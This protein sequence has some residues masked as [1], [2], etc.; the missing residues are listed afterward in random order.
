[1]GHPS[2]G[3]DAQAITCGALMLGAQIV[4]RVVIGGDPLLPQALGRGSLRLEQRGRGG[5]GFRH[6]E[7][8][9]SHSLGPVIA[10]FEDQLR[11]P[12]SRDPDAP[13]IRVH[14]FALMGGVEARVA[15]IEDKEKEKSDD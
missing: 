13:V 7:L 15:P 5:A 10:G 6:R 9:F 14:G 8:R 11:E 12:A 2:G 1:M 4:G 3:V